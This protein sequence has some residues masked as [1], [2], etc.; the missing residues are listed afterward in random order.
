[1][2]QSEVP[3]K[4]W[5]I[6]ST[7]YAIFLIDAMALVIVLFGTIEA[8]ASGLRMM[9][10]GTMT[11]AAR[12]EV[13]L[14][15][16]RIL[17]AGLTFQLGADIIETSITTGWESVARLGAIAVI[18]TFLNFFLERDLTEIRELQHERAEERK[19]ESRGA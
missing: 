8:F 11:N 19:R 7:E 17:V 13:W 18:R 5:L 12:R 15:Y 16:A 6:T 1:M 10:A 2:T 4:E 3:V 14:R 9:F